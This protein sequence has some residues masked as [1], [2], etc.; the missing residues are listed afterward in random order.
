MQQLMT[1]G[2]TSPGRRRSWLAWLGVL[3]WGLVGIASG[4]LAAAAAV[5][6]SY[7]ATYES[8]TQITFV[9]I[10]FA[11]FTAL[12]LGPAIALSRSRVTRRRALAGGMAACWIVVVA[13]AMPQAVQG[14]G[15][16]EEEIDRLTQQLVD[17]GTPAY[18][19]GPEADG[20]D[21]D[22]IY[23][24]GEYQA[25][26]VSVGY[27]LH[28]EGGDLGCSSDVYVRTFSMAPRYVRTY[29]CRSLDPI[30]DVP[31]VTRGT[32]RTLIL[33]TGS[34]LI[35]IEDWDSDDPLESELALARQLRP[36]GE[37]EPVT[38]L[39]APTPRTRAFVERYCPAP[40]LPAE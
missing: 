7:A 35:S 3:G 11:A 17:S 2:G 38:S 1:T 30:L 36:L 32:D 21:L 4:L 5:L 23:R 34:L 24:D 40:A 37:S 16:S 27:G 20:D 28:C 14:P 33:F 22:E 9:W 15:L 8:G 25:R 13:W 12:A 31:A 19:V 10:G 29:G 18:S 6:V 39:P 26:G